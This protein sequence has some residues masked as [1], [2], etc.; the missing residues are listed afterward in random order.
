[1]DRV[2]AVE[3]EPRADGMRAQIKPGLGID[4]SRKACVYWRCPSARDWQTPETTEQ[5]VSNGVR[6]NPLRSLAD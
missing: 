3:N 5:E 6:E 2:A 4:K 1:M